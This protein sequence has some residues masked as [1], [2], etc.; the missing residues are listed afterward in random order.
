M[1]K[2][3]ERAD[4]ELALPSDDTASFALR[5][6]KRHPV[7]VAPF[8]GRIGGNQEFVEHGDSIESEEILKKQ[9]D[10]VRFHVV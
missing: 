8:A 5:S 2:E 4:A 6:R 9:P 3:N 1:S 7:V 10:A